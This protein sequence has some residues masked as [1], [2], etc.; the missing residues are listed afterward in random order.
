M[1]SVRYHVSKTLDKN[2]LGLNLFT[3]AGWLGFPSGDES[4]KTWK[5]CTKNGKKCDGIRD[6]GC[7]C[8]YGQCRIS[9]K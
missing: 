2:N 1:D 4:C 8:K 6:A 7:I 3:P 5:D 9:C